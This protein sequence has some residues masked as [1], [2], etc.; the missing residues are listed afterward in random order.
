[1]R[2]HTVSYVTNTHPRY[3]NAYPLPH[4]F[5]GGDAS[6]T[7]RVRIGRQERT[8]TY[9]TE[10]NRKLDTVLRRISAVKN[11]LP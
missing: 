11:Y 8:W 3:Y 7:R 4:I 2:E 5:D 6:K 10:H 9:V 1:M